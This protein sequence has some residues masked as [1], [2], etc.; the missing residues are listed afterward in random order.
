MADSNYYFDGGDVKTGGEVGSVEDLTF[1]RFW[2]GA[3]LA[4]LA[5]APIDLNRTGQWGFFLATFAYVF[6]V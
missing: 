1:S 6:V 3:S 5:Y 2:D 4:G